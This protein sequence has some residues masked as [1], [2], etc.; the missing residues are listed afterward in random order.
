MRKILLVLSVLNLIYFFISMQFSHLDNIFLT[1]FF[2]PLFLNLLFLVLGS[3]TLSLD[4]TTK[5]MKIL[6]IA[7]IVINLLPVIVMS[8]LFIFL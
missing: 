5:Y 2:F 7:I 4:S 3:Y 8:L 6:S 1:P